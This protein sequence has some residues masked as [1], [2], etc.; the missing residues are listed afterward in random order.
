[1]A[2][3]PG[4]KK[5]RRSTWHR[6]P[7]PGGSGPWAWL[8]REIATLYPGCFALVMATGIISNALFFEDHHTLSQALF[9]FNAAA[10]PFLLAASIYPRRSVQPRAMG[11]SDQPAPGVLVLHDCRRHRRVRS[12][13]ASARFF[14]ARFGDVAVRVR[15]VVLPDLSELRRAHL[16][17]HR[18]RRQCRAWRLADRHRR[19]RVA[20]HSRHPGCAAIPVRPAPVFSC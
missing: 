6:H 4:R 20:R 7:P 9:I 16:P 17:Q 14:I 10:Y 12:R 5:R 11:R 8:R 18:A 15:A 2:C 3:P 19:H 1:M 13:P